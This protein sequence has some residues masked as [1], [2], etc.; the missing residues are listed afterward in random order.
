MRTNSDAITEDTVSVDGRE[1]THNILLCD[2]CAFFVAADMACEGCD[3]CVCGDDPDACARRERTFAETWGDLDVIVRDEPDIGGGF[4]ASIAR[5]DVCGGCGE[6]F[7]NDTWPAVVLAPEGCPCG[8]PI[9][10]V[11][12]G[13]AA[14]RWGGTHAHMDGEPLCPVMTATGYRPADHP[15]AR[16]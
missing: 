3:V 5:G 8:E 6:E 10:P 4:T 7:A 16:S 13:D 1:V 2:R 11:R 9:R 14:M 15:D 12:E